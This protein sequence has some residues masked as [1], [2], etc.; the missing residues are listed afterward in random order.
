MRSKLGL[1]GELAPEALREDDWLL[2]EDL[3][4][5]L[6]AERTDYTIFWRRLSQSMAAGW[7]DDPGATDA[8]QSVD[9]L[10]LDRAR[11]QAWRQRY[12]ERVGAADPLALGQAMLHT[13]PKFVLRNHLA[14]VAI[15]QAREGDF[16]EINRLLDLLHSP[17]DEHP[18]MQ[19][20]A[21]FP[22]DWAGQLEIS[23][24]S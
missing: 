20:Y 5:L 2:V 19:A 15:R 14:E 24:S 17:F 23:C 21:G 9:D 3:L 22:P 1:T 7:W 12:R 10:F 11:W 8:W 16:S 4:Q 13:N 6:A 18:G